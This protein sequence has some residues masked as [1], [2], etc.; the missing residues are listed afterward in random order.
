MDTI[1]NKSRETNGTMDMYERESSD[2]F[3]TIFIGD[4]NI[5]LEEVV[6]S[7]SSL[8]HEY[9]ELV[10]AKVFPESTFQ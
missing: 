6:A 2:G 7:T 9:E 10:V 3:L 4:I 1:T 8:E 5:S